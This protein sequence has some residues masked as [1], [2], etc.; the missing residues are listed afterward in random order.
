MYFIRSKCFISKILSETF[1]KLLK[2]LVKYYHKSM[3]VFLKKFP[4]TFIQCSTWILKFYENQ[5][6]SLQKDRGGG[7]DR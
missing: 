4:V 6:C 2:D 5:C 1:L 7:A 3:E